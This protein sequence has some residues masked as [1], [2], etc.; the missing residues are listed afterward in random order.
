MSCGQLRVKL[1]LTGLINVLYCGS[2]SP[3]PLHQMRSCTGSCKITLPWGETSWRLWNG[4][5][6]T[7][8]ISLK[9][10]GKNLQKTKL[11]LSGVRV[12]SPGSPFLQLCHSSIIEGC[13]PNEGRSASSS[14]VTVNLSILSFPQVS[15]PL[16]SPLIVQQAAECGIGGGHIN[17]ISTRQMTAL[18]EAV[19]FSCCPSG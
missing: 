12:W 16:G 8:F 5:T 14:S 10:K 15:H 18:R 2:P 6:N 1:L 13:F 11:P 7:V 4:S 17:V 9:K 3:P 19:T